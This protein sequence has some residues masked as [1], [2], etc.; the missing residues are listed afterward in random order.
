MAS[1]A[2]I[3]TAHISGHDATHR[4]T[5]TVS[6]Y[7]SYVY[8]IPV[9]AGA[10]KL[11]AATAASRTASLLA[12]ASNAPAPATASSSS[13]SSTSTAAAAAVT[14]NAVLAAVAVAAGAA[15]LI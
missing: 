5:T 3:Q 10:D 7:K 14:G 15:A 12:P 1:C 11:P 6:G 2:Y 9:T 8:P 4:A 13:S